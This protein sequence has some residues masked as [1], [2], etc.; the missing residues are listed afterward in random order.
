[1]ADVNEQRRTLYLDPRLGWTETET[2]EA[3][4]KLSSLWRT[5]EV[6][7]IVENQLYARFDRGGWQDLNPSDLTR[8]NG[9]EQ[10]FQFECKPR[11]GEQGNFYEISSIRYVDQEM[12]PV[13]EGIP[14]FDLDLKPIKPPQAAGGFCIPA[15][16][17]PLF[18]QR[19]KELGG[20]LSQ[21]QADV[22]IMHAK[23]QRLSG[24]ASELETL[25]A[26]SRAVIDQ[27]A[28]GVATEVPSISERCTRAHALYQE[29]GRLHRQIQEEEMATDSPGTPIELRAHAEAYAENA[30]QWMAH[31]ERL[32]REHVSYEAQA[33]LR[34]KQSISSNLPGV[35]SPASTARYLLMDVVEFYTEQGYD[36]RLTR[37]GMRLT[38]G[39]TV[40][41][42]GEKPVVRKAGAETSADQLLGKTTAERTQ[43]EL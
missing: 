32:H 20:K 26:E 21:A 36:C 23:L 6:R 5:P 22:Q 12:K 28:G 25:C 24:I 18:T 9:H 14:L 1:M 43:R 4:L 41:E 19:V 37:D 38:L 17:M 33:K 40:V 39:D 7:T 8:L 16:E 30:D 13:L 10:G 35:E 3:K 15:S 29:A 34:T 27:V 2:P 31:I 42:L 11:M